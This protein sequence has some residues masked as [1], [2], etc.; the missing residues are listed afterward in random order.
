MNG[1]KE[2]GDNNGNNEGQDA[3]GLINDLGAGINV[4]PNKN[5]LTIKLNPESKNPNF[6]NKKLKGKIN[7]NEKL[8]GMDEE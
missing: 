8:S 2:V 7:I 1:I 6:M 4:K 3:G 5:I